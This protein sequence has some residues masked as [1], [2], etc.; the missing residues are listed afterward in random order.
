MDAIK[1]LFGKLA[2]PAA[3]CQN[4]AFI[5]AMLRQAARQGLLRANRTDLAH[6]TFTVPADC[7]AQLINSNENSRAV[8][9]IVEEVMAGQLDEIK[10]IASLITDDT[11]FDV[12]KATKMVS[13]L[14]RKLMPGGEANARLV[15]LLAFS[16][17]LVEGLCSHGATAVHSI[18][19]AIEKEIHEQMKDALHDLPVRRNLT[20]SVLVPT[21]M[22]PLVC[23]CVISRTSSKVDVSLSIIWHTGLE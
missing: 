17:V 13:L 10:S 9:A 22:C 5:S 18:V 12:A 19:I 8:W 4:Q 23:C 3:A 2:Q 16:S 7:D 11:H 6:D 1:S 15:I 14:T 21:A 20:N